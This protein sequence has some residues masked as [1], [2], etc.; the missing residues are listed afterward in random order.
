[1][2]IYRL[3]LAVVLAAL[4]SLLPA[5]SFDWYHGGS[6][7]YTLQK[8][9]S[10][11][12]D[13]AAGMF[14]EDMEAVTGNAAK[15]S[16]A[17]DVL[18]YQLDMASNKDLKA[19]ASMLVP[20]LT[21]IT[22]PDAYW[23]GVRNGKIV[24]VGS[25]G[26][27]TAYGL[28]HLSRLAGVSPWV[29]WGDVTP[30]RRDRLSIDDGFETT[31]IPSVDYRAIALSDN[32]G[33]DYK[34][35]FGL[36]LRL[37]ANTLCE[38]WDQGEAPDHFP[39]D[40]REESDAYGMVL[41]TPHD[42]NSLRL[43]DHK[44]SLSVDLGW[45]DDNYGY[46]ERVGQDDAKNT[47]VVYHLSYEGQPHDYQ[48]LCTTQPGL[49]AN[50]MKTA[51]YNGGDRLWMVVV[52][53]PKTAAY[54]L[55]LFMDMAWDINTVKADNVSAHMQAWLAE[56]FGKPAADALMAPLSQYFRLVGIRRPEFMDFSR[57][58][59]KS[60][61]N[62]NGDGGVKNTD[63]NAE[64]FGN[65]LERYLNDYVAVCKGVTAASQ[66]VDDSRKDAFFAAVEYPV[67]GSALMADKTLQAQE[68]RLIGRPASFHHDDEALESAARSVRAYRDLKKLTS[69][70]GEIAGGKWSGEMNDAPRALQVF[71]EPVLPDKLSDAEVEKYGKHEPVE[72]LLDDDNTIV[73]N[74]CQY[75]KASGGARP[76]D[77][78]GH[79]L[80]AVELYAGDSLSYSF[81]SPVVGG[82]LRMAFIPTHALDGGS[83][84]CSVSI[85]G[86]SP[87][88]VIVTDGSRSGRWADGVLRGQALVTLPVSLSEGMHTLTVKALSDHLLL[89]Q[90]MIDR[91]TDR[92]FYVFP[93]AE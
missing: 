56:Q 60:K 32:E 79:S 8:K 50:E 85:D 58:T 64:E 35:L 93:I 19:L 51:F 92:H 53:K 15:S 88:T 76:V 43:T 75:A 47:G 80:K 37:G 4:P 3:V 48:W 34:R 11:V 63:F 59:A 25:N 1:M 62:E 46:I 13:I 81:H 17:G 72:A 45:A 89:D 36:M 24:I 86:K 16:A 41:A 12:V 42:G 5:K 87:T 57:Q 30:V 69:K 71:G 49:V 10:P 22:K 55:S 91:D 44:K 38:G 31:Q 14:S 67:Y 6:V 18:L 33:V 21:F 9:I 54:Q 40:I 74:A 83:L 78:L 28:M 90:W 2:K 70:Y 66:L 26:R 29:W 39:H 65:E 27:G 77:L 52:R 82:V 23:I 61:S 7:T 73:R 68:A 20:V 84:Q